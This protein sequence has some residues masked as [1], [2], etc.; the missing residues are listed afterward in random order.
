MT[1]RPFAEQR[2][3]SKLEFDPDRTAVLVIDMLNDFLEDGGAMVLSGG[4]TLYEPINRLLEHARRSELP[5]IWVCDEHPVEDD[6]EFEKRIPHCFAGSWGAEVVDALDVRE[7]DYR[8]RK[9]RYS[10]FFETDLDLRLRELK[11]ES[12]IVTGLST[13]I[14]VRSTI[15]DAFFRGYQVIVPEDC[16]AATGQREQESTL[17]DIETHYGLTTTLDKVVE[18]IQ[19]ASTARPENR[20]DTAEQGQVKGGLST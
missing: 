10:G 19:G 20:L 8:V 7:N 18:I 3:A 14:C 1:S 17:Y 12:L 6:V 9:R 16:V 2:V 5:I 4:K 13:N 15:H 11:A